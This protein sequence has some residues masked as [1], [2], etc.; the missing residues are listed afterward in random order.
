MPYETALKADAGQHLPSGMDPQILLP[1]DD[2]LRAERDHLE[3]S[4]T[5]RR[6]HQWLCLSRAEKAAIR[7]GAILSTIS[8]EGERK[9]FCAS[10]VLDARARWRV[11]LGADSYRPSAVN[12]L[13]SFAAWSRSFAI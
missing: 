13:R 2:P 4:L 7:M 12:A 10:V 9:L 8:S 3:A 11:G 5:Q 1:A 6:A